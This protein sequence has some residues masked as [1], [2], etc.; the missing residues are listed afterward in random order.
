MEK[1][2]FFRTN[3]YKRLIVHQKGDLIMWY[4][5]LLVYYATL[6]EILTVKWCAPP[7]ASC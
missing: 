7:L 6:Y 2:Y 5:K 1:K 3:K 4:S